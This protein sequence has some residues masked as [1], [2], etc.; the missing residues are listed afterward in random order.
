[1]TL[2]SSDAVSAL[3]VIRSGRISVSATFPAAVGA[4]PPGT[5]TIPMCPAPYHMSF[6]S[7]PD[8]NATLFPSGLNTGFDS[9]RSV[10]TS[11]RGMPPFAGTR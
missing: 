8:T 2:R 4:S 1:M 5:A 7:P 10:A 3:G 9:A 11:G 6:G